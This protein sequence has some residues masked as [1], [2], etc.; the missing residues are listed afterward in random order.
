MER[1]SKE[2]EQLHEQHR[3]VEE[4]ENQKRL[5]L[6]EKQKKAE[7]L[8]PLQA[9]E[10]QIQNVLFKLCSQT[11]SFCIQEVKEEN[12]ETTEFIGRITRKRTR[13]CVKDPSA[14]QN[15]LKNGNGNRGKKGKISP[16]KIAVSSKKHVESKSKIIKYIFVHYFCFNGDMRQ[17]MVEKGTNISCEEIACRVLFSGYAY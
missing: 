13:G 6:L 2:A 11:Y 14:G 7:E 15:K 3:I 1:Q 10:V 8:F 4:E 9:I 16:S 5:W 12:L 17:L